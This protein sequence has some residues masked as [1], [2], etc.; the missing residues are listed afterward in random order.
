MHKSKIQKLIQ[1]TDAIK[2]TSLCKELPDEEKN[3]ISQLEETVFE[4]SQFIE[5][6]FEEMDRISEITSKVNSGVL[7]DEVFNHTFDS[8]RKIIP[9]NRIGV[10]LLVNNGEL[11][12]SIWAK[13]DLEDVKIK[14]GYTARMTSSS[15][16][17]IIIKSNQPRIINDLEKY[18]SEH[19]HSDSTRKIVNE[20]ILSSLTFPLIALGKPIGFIFFSSVKKNTY[21]DVHLDVFCKIAD[22]FAI[23]VEKGRLYDELLQKNRELKKLDELKDDFISSVSH[24]LNTPLTIIH[25]SIS[26]LIDGLLGPVPDNQ[27]T[28]LIDAQ[29]NCRRLGTLI[30]DLLDLSKIEAQRLKLHKEEINI[31]S[32]AKEI[33]STHQVLLKEKNVNACLKTSSE[34]IRLPIDPMRIFQIFSNLMNNAIKHSNSGT[35]TITIT[36]HSDH[37]ECAVEDQGTGISAQDL[38]KAFDKFEQFNRKSKSGYQGTGLGLPITKRLVELHGGDIW[39]SSEENR[40]TKLTFTLPKLSPLDYLKK[41][42]DTLIASSLTSKQTVF[43]VVMIQLHH[44]DKL[45]RKRS[46]DQ[47]TQL[48]AQIENALWSSVRG[49]IDRVVRARDS[50][51]LILPQ[52]DKEA[53]YTLGESAHHSINRLLLDEFPDEQLKL[54]WQ[55]ISYPENAKTSDEI[56]TLLQIA[57]DQ[58]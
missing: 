19:P 21:R 55:V 50:F 13:S 53:A 28:I 43:S 11:I 40:G 33:I 44:F 17:Q 3:L 20:G 38:P 35:I 4:L 7:L 54:S 26:Q 8:F 18:L 56:L 48:I 15:S 32:L 58:P 31:V 25:E 6:K 42:L 39:I 52:T 30:I 5:R 45:I 34:N 41:S 1:I 14:K 51:W 46:K 36:E 10:S 9:Y 29:K 47:T 23:I 27:K 16:L 2:K 49:S 12:R 22:Q 24:E 37:I 57:E